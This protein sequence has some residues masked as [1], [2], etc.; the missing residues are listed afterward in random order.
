MCWIARIEN[1]R[2]IGLEHHY[3]R[4]WKLRE[5]LRKSL[6]L[7]S[8]KKA[9]PNR[10]N[11]PWR[12][13]KRTRRKGILSLSDA[14]PSSPPCSLGV[15]TQGSLTPKLI[16]DSVV[17]PSKTSCTEAWAEHLVFCWNQQEW[18]Q[19]EKLSYISTFW[20]QETGRRFDSHMFPWTAQEA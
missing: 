13:E 7:P 19:P 16:L 15:T 10:N 5:W 14:L 9:L 4:W 3:S 6:L 8:N 17:E 1:R 20:G 12:E 18:K 11:E 2:E